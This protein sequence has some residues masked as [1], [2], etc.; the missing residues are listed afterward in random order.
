MGVLVSKYLSLNNISVEMKCYSR[1][2]TIAGSD[3]SGG[4]GIEADIKTISACGCFA[5]TVITAVV[6]ENTQGVYGIHPIPVDMVV[7][8]IESV[9]NDI[10]T[11]AVKVGMLYSAELVKAV[12]DTLKKYDVNNIVV[13]PVMVATSGDPLVKTEIGDALKSQL[14]PIAC[15]ATPNIPEAKHL[16]GNGSPIANIDDMKSVAKSMSCYCSNILLKGGHLDSDNLVD[17]LYSSSDDKYFELHS[18]RI[19]TKN[20]HGTGCTLSSAIASHLAKGES[21]A[22]A[23]ESAKKYIDTAIRLGAEYEIGKGCGPV[24]HFFDM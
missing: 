23:V 14:F 8:Q 15:V 4:A 3:P 7:G 16:L 6:N 20:T 12:A 22:D 17:V 19:N 21:V 2:L 11:D 24:K 5:T 1:V 9:L 18:K 10:G 13:D